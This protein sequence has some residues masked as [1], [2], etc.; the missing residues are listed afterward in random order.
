MTRL[1]P[2]LALVLV[3]CGEDPGSAEPV[4]CP[5]AR[6]GED[7]T[8]GEGFGCTP[9]EVLGCRYPIDPN[10]IYPDGGRAAGIPACRASG[11]VECENGVPTC[12]LPGAP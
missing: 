7:W 2:L 9:E 12:A 10:D 5:A 3:G 8:H 4:S 1:L 6:V 11:F